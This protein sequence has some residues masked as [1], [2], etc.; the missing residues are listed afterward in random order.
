MKYPGS[1]LK[2]RE[3]W[4]QENFVSKESDQLLCCSELKTMA[5]NILITKPALRSHSETGG[6]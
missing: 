3:F 5:A 6:K 1:I 4:T 2:D